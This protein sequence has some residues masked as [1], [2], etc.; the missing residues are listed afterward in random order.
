LRGPRVIN[1]ANILKYEHWPLAKSLTILLDFFAQ[2]MGSPVEIEYAL[3]TKNNERPTL[4]LLQIKPL[5]KQ[6]S[7]ITVNIE[8]VNKENSVLLLSGGMGNGHYTNISD[9]VYMNL[10]K[11]D[12]TKTEQMAKEVAS[13]NKKLQHENREYVLIGVGRWGSRDKFIGIPVF[14][15]HI[16]NARIIVEMGLKNLPLEASMGSHFFH[17]VT[18]MNVGYFS[19]PYGSKANIVNLDLLNKQEL[20]NETTFF[21]HVRFEK[22][23]DIK[24]D[25]KERIA[26]AEMQ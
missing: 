5:I 7:D 9:V 15:S 11:F 19:A 26:V 23:L 14:W 25:G 16:A 12:K 2:A 10:D 1:F 17:N 8:T 4:H 3:E 18:S 20:I 6:N 13:I 24:M 22:P 21:K